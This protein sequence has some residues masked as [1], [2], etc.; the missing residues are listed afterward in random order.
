MCRLHWLIT[1]YVYGKVVIG[2]GRHEHCLPDRTNSP[3]FAFPMQVRL[4]EGI[5]QPLHWPRTVVWGLSMI[6]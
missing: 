3:G 4:G 2:R 1:G 6:W 5:Y